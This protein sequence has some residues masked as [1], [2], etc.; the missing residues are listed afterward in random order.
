MVIYAAAAI[1]TGAYFWRER[2]SQF[3]PVLHLLFP[4]VVTA[5]LIL[6]R[7]QVR[8]STSPRSYS[9]YGLWVFVGWA[10]VGFVLLIAMRLAGKEDW[11]IHAGE[12]AVLR[13]ESPQ[14][15]EHRPAV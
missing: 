5:A 2:R 10:V 11:L 13:P 6:V 3:N 8:G 12:A 1:A 15:L 14:E 4:L 7:V 9:S